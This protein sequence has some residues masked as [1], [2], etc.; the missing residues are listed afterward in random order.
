MDLD[1]DLQIWEGFVKIS[2]RESIILLV[3]IMMEKS[4]QESVEA[5]GEKVM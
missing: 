5:L 2:K 3:M 4:W 1:L